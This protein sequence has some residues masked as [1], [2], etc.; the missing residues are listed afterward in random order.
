[1]KYLAA[2][3]LCNLSGNKP[4]KDSVKAVLK[5]AGVAVDDAKV[6]EV[7]AAFEGKEFDSVV[8]AGLKKVGSA[9]P[10]AGPAAGAAAAPAAKADAKKDE[11]K[12]DD[13]KK[14]KEP[15]PADDDDLFGGGLF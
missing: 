5:A 6:N 11:P 7:F 8:S 3:A 1:M 2:Y 4:T 12:K 9:G 13:K 10:A 15:E 14:A